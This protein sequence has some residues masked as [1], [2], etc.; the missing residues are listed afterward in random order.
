MGEG[1]VG[2]GQCL[3][4]VSLAPLVFSPRL[5]L[6]V[7]IEASPGHC[8]L[9][10]WHSPLLWTLVTFLPTGRLWLESGRGQNGSAMSGVPEVPQPSCLSAI[11]RT[12]LALVST[13]GEWMAS[14]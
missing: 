6:Q 10:H 8:P 14:R 9:H 2:W 11:S 12:M 3:V 1:R 7:R 5:D 13:L 4:W